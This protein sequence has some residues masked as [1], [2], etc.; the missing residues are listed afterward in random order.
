M[1][2]VIQLCTDLEKE[3]MLTFKQLV[4]SYKDLLCKRQNYKEY[5]H[6]NK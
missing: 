2:T 3:R 4:N 6:K 5:E 1:Y